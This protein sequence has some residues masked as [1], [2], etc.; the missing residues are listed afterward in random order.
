MEACVNSECGITEYPELDPCRLCPRACGADRRGGRAGV[1]HADAALRVGRA[2]LHMWEEPCISGSTGSGA[3]FFAGCA[4]GCV[5]CQNRALTEPGSGT[6]ISVQ[7]LSEIF[8]ELQEQGAA[9]INLVTGDH[10]VLHAADAIRAARENGLCIPVVWNCSGY[11]SARCLEILNGLIDI[12]LT[13]FKYIRPETAAKYS[14][15]A[16]YPETAKAALREMVRQCPVPEFVSAGMMRKGVIVRH[17]L[18]PGHVNEAKE[19]IHYLLTEYGQKIYISLMNQYT[20]QAGISGERFP[21]LKRKVTK[22]EYGSLVQYALDCGLENGF[23]QEGGTAEESFIPAFDGTGV[24]QGAGEK[25]RIRAA[26]KSGS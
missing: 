2:A 1:C 14:R 8:L 20:P 6:A 10:Y 12:Y 15:A 4:L 3:V 23:I 21:E 9:N 25:D 26:E 13:D 19:I 18:L 22:R 24:Y 17:L 11:E 5:Y 16:D 7:R